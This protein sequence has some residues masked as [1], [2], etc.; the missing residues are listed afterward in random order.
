MAR[1]A[2]Q[3]A[4]PA[5]PSAAPRARKAKTAARRS[6]AVRAAEPTVASSSGVVYA[7]LFKNGRSQAVRLPKAFQIDGDRVRIRRVA[8]G[9]LLETEP[10]DV[11]AW[12]RRM[13]SYGADPL[14]PNGRE[15][16]P[17]PESKVS[18]D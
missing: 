8:E 6:A 11:E 14:F 16:P 17:M 3:T 2:S 4:R 9:I 18:F 10:F 13:D 12:F 5:S 15:Q 1:R 7:K